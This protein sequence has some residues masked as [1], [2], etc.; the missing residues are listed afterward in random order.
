[1]K[2][3][4]PET[5][6]FSSTRL[7][8]ISAKMQTYVDEGKLAGTITTVA[9]HGQTV[10]LETTGW[11]DR[12]AQRPMELDAIFRI[13]SMTKPITAAAIMTLYEEGYFTLNTPIS[14]SFLAF[15]TSRCSFEKPGR[16]SRWRT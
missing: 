1:M 15:G 10:H 11:M 14:D 7:Q 4:T 6:G 9:R 12:E 16:T 8:R 5:V 2:V 3:V 13:A